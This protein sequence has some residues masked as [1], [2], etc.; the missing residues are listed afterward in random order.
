VTKLIGGE[1]VAMMSLLEAEGPAVSVLLPVRNGA[2]YLEDAVGSILRQSFA[3]FELLLVDDGSDDATPAIARR[4]AATDAR[5]RI[6]TQDRH[7]IVAALNRGL[8]AARAKLIARMDADDLAW[9]DRLARQVA[10]F[11]GDPD[12]A[13]VASAW[14]IVSAAGDV[15]RTIHPPQ[16]D[17]GLRAALARGNVLAHPTI[18]FRR[19]AVL[20]L[21]GYRD[22]FP[23]AEDYDLWLR[24]LERHKAMCL[25]D[26]LLDYREHEGQATWSDIEQRILSEM[27]VQAAASRRAA[28]QPDGGDAPGACGRA[29][30][31]A[32]G[33]NEIE[34]AAGVVARAL[35]SAKAARAG[36]NRQATQA[37]ARL[38]LRQPGLALRTRL[39]FVLL[40][41]Q[42]RWRRIVRLGGAN[43]GV[44]PLP[45]GPV[46]PAPPPAT[47]DVWSRR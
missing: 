20:A 11:R 8:H 31:R 1:C 15:R 38:G 2:A 46:S 17:A 24:L 19:D 7:G 12:L 16:T 39:H 5:L 14:R 44:R 27:A 25:A 34:I 45:P 21:G 3:D 29:R 23:L 33:L 35:G 13:L 41:W 28:G 36:G 43:A 10:I 22:G 9:P 4:L 26:V 37:A 6:L 32:L 18:M 47:P 40:L 42:S 30:L